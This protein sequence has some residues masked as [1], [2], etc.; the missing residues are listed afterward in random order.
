M[1]MSPIE[2]YQVSKLLAEIDTNKAAGH[3]G[4]TGKIL[5]CL[6]PLLA[7]PLTD[8]INK[9]VS[10]GKYPDELKRANVTLIPKPGFDGNLN[11]LRPISVLPE[12]NKIVEK[13]LLYPIKEFLHESG[14]IDDKQYGF[15]RDSGTDLAIIE[16][17]HTISMALDNNKI[18]GVVFFDISKAFDTINHE[19]LLDKLEMYGVRGI[20]QQLIRSYFEGRSQAVK[21]NGTLSSYQI[22][23]R[24]IGQGTSLGPFYFVTKLDDFKNLPLKGKSSRFADDVCS[25]TTGTLSEINDILDS[26]KHDVELVEDYHRINGMTLNRKKTKLMII[27]KKNT[28]LDENAI[29]KFSLANNIERVYLNIYLGV[30][31]HHNFSINP[32]IIQLIKKMNPIVGILSKLKWSLPDDVLLQIYFAHVHSHISNLPQILSIANEQEINSLQTLQNRALKHVLKLPV[33]HSSLELYRDIAK[34]ILPVRGIIC[35][36]TL[37]FIHKAVIG[38]IRTELK[39]NKSNKNL[40][41]DGKLIVFRNNNSVLML[42]NITCLG[43]KQYNDLPLEI[44]TSTSIDS[45]QTKLK[46][47][48]L[49]M[50]QKFL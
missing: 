27:A 31:I 5:K 9:I 48:L 10:H 1:F 11:D 8:L 29:L 6:G 14:Y 18:I 21:F 33:R 26:M 35:Y 36:S 46:S 38:V 17:F 44:R 43:V 47:H 30:P 22:V 2:E 13:S 15:R 45:F 19:V 16:L 7:E 37:T 20:V 49:S 32:R 23:T 39:F 50:P 25:Y 12:I 3:D 24:G 41:N 40:R 4:I 34:T 28:Q 42:R